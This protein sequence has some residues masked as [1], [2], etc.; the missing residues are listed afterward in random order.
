MYTNILITGYEY[1][2]Q[3]ELFGLPLVHIAFGINPQTGQP[4]VAKGIIAIGNIALGLVAVGGFAMGGITLAGF[5]LG[6]LAIGGFS[7]GV[8]AVGGLAFALHTAVGGFA[9]SAK[10]ALG[11]L[12][13][14]PNTLEVSCVNFERLLPFRVLSGIGCR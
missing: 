2:S 5:S 10:F 1:R 14:S 4:R 8:M 11:G 12:M 13:L 6:I 3:T 7:F 9:I